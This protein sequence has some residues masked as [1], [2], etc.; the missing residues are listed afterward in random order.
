MFLISKD[1]I[2]Q[3]S[4]CQIELDN[5]LRWDRYPSFTIPYSSVMN[6]SIKLKGRRWGIQPGF[7]FP[8]KNNF[9]AKVGLGYHNYSFD[10]VKVNSPLFGTQLGRTMKRLVYPGLSST[11]GYATKKYWYNTISATIGLEKLFDVE[12]NWSIITGLILTNYY[13]FSQ[14]YVLSPVTYKESDKHYFGLSANIYA[15]MQKKFGKF[16]IGPKILFPIGDTWKKDEVFPPEEDS[17]S[18]SKWLRGFGVGISFN[19]SLSKRQ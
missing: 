12:K 11:F 19:Y 7:K 14:R 17:K 6:A 9:F 15:G 13:T 16:G 2:S 18:R 5:Y 4:P 1:A 3:K 10:E 8:F